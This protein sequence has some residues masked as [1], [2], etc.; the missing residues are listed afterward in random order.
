MTGG[1]S[2]AVNWNWF[3]F[4]KRPFSTKYPGAGKA[5]VTGMPAG[6]VSTNGDG[7]PGGTNGSSPVAG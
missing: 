1:A 6:V 3:V 4:P 2:E 5:S 7:V